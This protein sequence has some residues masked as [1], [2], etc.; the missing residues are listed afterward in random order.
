MKLL[1]THIGSE[2]AG[3]GVAAFDWNQ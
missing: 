1:G 3:L 2:M